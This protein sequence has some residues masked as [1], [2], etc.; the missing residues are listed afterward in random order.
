[1]SVSEYPA[2]K[3]AVARVEKFATVAQIEERLAVLNAMQFKPGQHG[4]GS[5]N[6]EVQ[7]LRRRLEVLQNPQLL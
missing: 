3:A 4:I 6:L 1:M 2:K 7:R 5:R